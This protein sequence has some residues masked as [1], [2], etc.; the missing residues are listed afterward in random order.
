MKT[1]KNLAKIIN[2]AF[3]AGLDRVEAFEPVRAMLRRRAVSVENC[4][5]GSV[6]TYA[7]GSELFQYDPE[8]SAMHGGKVS[9]L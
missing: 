5:Y 6:F 2:A 3:D 9:L 1:A 8:K 4:K 7:D